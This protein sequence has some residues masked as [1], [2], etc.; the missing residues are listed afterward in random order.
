M[1]FWKR[2]IN[3]DNVLFVFGTWAHQDITP[4]VEEPVVHNLE[5]KSKELANDN[6]EKNPEQSRG[7]GDKANHQ[8]DNA[9]VFNYEDGI[10]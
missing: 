7:I 5:Q 4:D 6:K 8:N 1:H 9:K 10:H 3:L 2:Q